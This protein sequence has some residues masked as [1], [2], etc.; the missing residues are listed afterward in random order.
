[1]IAPLTG[2]AAT[3]GRS[4]QNGIETALAQLGAS[5]RLE[6]SYEDD[7]FM[8]SK[9]IAAFNKLVELDGVDIVVTIGSTPSNA[10][11]PLAQRRAILH[12]AAASATSVARARPYVM[13]TWS[14]GL[15]E[16]ARIAKEALRRQLSKVA[17]VFT[18]ND[19]HEAV[20]AGFIQHFPADKLV[21]I[22]EHS[23]EQP[24]YKTFLLKARSVSADGIALL[25]HPGGAGLL[26]RQAAELH[27]SP[28][29]FSAIQ[30]EDSREHKIAKGALKGA[31]YV[32]GGCSESFKRRYLQRY[33][34]T[35]V[36][37]L[38][39]LHYD[40]L[41]VLNDFKGRPSAKRLRDY[42]LKIQDRKGAIGH[43]SVVKAHDDQYLT[44]PLVVR[45]VP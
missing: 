42:L 43:F 23:S 15:A 9:T 25:L 24:D 27:Y 3:F 31:W 45:T 38:A 32:T 18:S 17:L 33:G 29:F 26:A 28:T 6:V 14:S 19:Y 5:A 13:R 37:S 1:M 41:L 36:I 20:K 44:L 7:Q 10:V 8:P 34:D 35:D 21:L 39:A 2:S 16:G 22:Q 11:A 30:L 12:L 40:L 4:A